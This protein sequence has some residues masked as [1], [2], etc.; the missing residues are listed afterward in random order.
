[1]FNEQST[2][3]GSLFKVSKDMLL[4]SSDLWVGSMQIDSHIVVASATA[5]FRDD[6]RFAGFRLTLGTTDP[7]CRGLGYC[8]EL[9]PVG[10]FPGSEL[11]GYMAHVDS[12]DMDQVLQVSAVY[13][14]NSD[15]TSRLDVSIE[16]IVRASEAA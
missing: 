12:P 16:P 8:T 3:S 10:P 6:Q 4:G 11:R 13:A 15:G 7:I 2:G 1:M 9:R 14:T 5:M